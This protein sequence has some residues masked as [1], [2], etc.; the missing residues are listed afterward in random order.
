MLGSFQMSELSSEDQI[1]LMDCTDLKEEL[2]LTRQLCQILS[3]II[4]EIPDTVWVTDGNAVTM[5]INKA[6]EK[7]YGLYRNEFIGKHMAELEG[8]KDISQSG[9]LLAMK[10]QRA[11]DLRIHF[12]KVGRDAFIRSQPVFDPE[13][14]ITMVI[15]NSRNF[16]EIKDLEERLIAA[17][18]KVAHYKS[19]LTAI[20]DQIVPKNDI[21]AKDKASLDMLAKAHKVAKVDATTLILGETGV[22][23]EELAKYIHENSVRSQKRFLVINCGALTESLIESELFGYEKGSFTGAMKDGKMGLFQAAGGGTLFLD[24]VGELTL[25]TQVKLLRVL[26]EKTV[27]RIGGVE[28]IPVD[29]RI[30]AATN[31]DLKQMVAEKTFRED[32]YYRLNVVPIK[33]PPLRERSDDILPLVN[34]FLEI[35]N[36]R[37]GFSKRFSGLAYQRLKEYPWPGNIRE[38]R[39]IVEQAVIMS[40]NNRISV[41]DLPICNAC[42]LPAIDLE[43]HS[44]NEIIE[45]VEFDYINRAY[46]QYGNIRKAAE[47]LRINYTTFERKRKAYIQKYT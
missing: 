15:S 12:N 19:E 14:H 41:N 46:E 24:E 8:N 37:Y 47:S 16:D 42:R 11:I 21:I 32:L 6:F 25:S 26:Q 4:D 40:E 35:F 22:G 39:N 7:L 18:S 10:E 3:T 29:V 31:R 5:L 23:K 9:T 28:H 36:T 33:I 27:M 43:S 17:E 34:H 38:L 45:Q 2:T 20:R 1:Q 30:I 13:G 44:L